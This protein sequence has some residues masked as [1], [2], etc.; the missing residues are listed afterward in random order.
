MTE[1]RGAERGRSLLKAKI[2]FNNRMSTVDCIIKN[3]SASGARILVG[4][5]LSVPREFDLHVPLKG[6]TYRAQ[7]RW[8]DAESMGVEFLDANVS[9]Q[10]ESRL[11]RLEDENMRLRTVVQNLSKR[12]AD[13]GQEV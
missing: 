7:M 1:L 13:L 12:L 3:I 9:E 2:I 5:T 11:H 6:K 10:S 8:R 4:S